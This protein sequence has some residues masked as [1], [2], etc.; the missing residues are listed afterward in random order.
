MHKRS[1]LSAQMFELNKLVKQFM[2]EEGGFASYSLAEGSIDAD[3][4][5]RY[6]LTYHEKGSLVTFYRGWALDELI[7]PLRSPR[8]L[9]ILQ[10]LK[11]TD[12]TL[13]APRLDPLLQALERAI[14]KSVWASPIREIKLGYRQRA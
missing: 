13:V 1:R 4:E 5:D 3:D 10:F 14:T 11:E 9:R 6:E 8:F 7:V 12:D 2:G